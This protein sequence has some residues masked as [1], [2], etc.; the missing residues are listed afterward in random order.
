MAGFAIA[1]MGQCAARD[2]ILDRLIEASAWKTLLD[3]WY[4]CESPV[5]LER[6]ADL[7][8]ATDT[9]VRRSAA[10]CLFR[11]TIKSGSDELLSRCLFLLEARNG[12]AASISESDLDVSGGMAATPLRLSLLA[13]LARSSN[14][15]LKLR[16]LREIAKI[17]EAATTPEIVTSLESEIWED[18]VQVAQEAIDTVQDMGIAA[19]TEKIVERLLLCVSEETELTRH[20][21]TALLAMMARGARVFQRRG[22][23][24]TVQ[25][26]EDLA[27]LE[28]PT[29]GSCG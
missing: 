14:L 8:N 25:T 2:D 15:A 22:G 19:A 7:L 20:A 17:G 12:E 21:S 16:A 9:K 11:M 1:R 28:F 29:V 10:Q 27:S 26:V 23:G 5:I 4:S 24:C 6:L 3:L 18:D 13:T